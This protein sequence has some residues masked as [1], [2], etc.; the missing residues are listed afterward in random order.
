MTRARDRAVAGAALAVLVALAALVVWLVLDAQRAGI[1]SRERARVEQVQ[2]LSKSLDTRVQQAYT[3]F[4]ASAGAPGAW[5][6]KLGDPADA[7]K[8]RPTSPQAVSGALLVDQSGTIVNGGLLVDPKT[9]GQ[10]YRSSGLAAVLGGEPAILPMSSGFT[11]T[12]PV[13]TIAVPVRST[14][15][16]VVGGYLYE[17]P[18]TAD[19]PF[20]QEIAQLHAGRTGVFSVLDSS[21][22][23]VASSEEST[24]TQESALSASVRRSG[25]HRLKGNVVAVADVPSAQWFFAFEQTTSEFQGDL[26]RPVRAAVAVI[27]GLVLLAGIVSVVALTRRLRA[28]HEEQRRLAEISVAREEFASIVSHELRTPVAGLLGFL[29]TTIDHWDAMAEG[30]RHR[31]VERALEN[32]E[33]LQHLSADVLDTTAMD[34]GNVQLQ[35]EP[36]DLR[37]IAEDTAETVSSVYGDHTFDIGGDDRVE[38]RADAARI[39]QVIGNVLENAVKNSPPGTSVEVTVSRVDGQ[40][41]VSVRD[42]GSGIAATDRERIFDKYTRAG[43]G[44]GRGTGLGLYLSRQ[45]VQAHGGRI[46]VDEA[47][48]AGTTIVFT[49]PAREGERE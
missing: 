36:V 24:L 7:A 37:A 10:S 23:V 46:W 44:L 45:I 14:T 39:R 16:E 19:S 22:R 4:G 42:H 12:H 38:V 13:V 34:A 21:G 3:A 5:S 49:L 35:T 40:A 27:A 26:T 6:M 8:L 17:S 15:G 20:S 47:P 41:R 11:T 28:A 9:I 1:R 25:F 33:R 43:A 18:V 32:A 29:Q 2:L 31:A 48:G 30:E